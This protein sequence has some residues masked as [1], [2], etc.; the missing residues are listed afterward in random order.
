VKILHTADWHLNSVLGRQQRNVDLKPALAQIASYL[1][2]Y[3]VDVM[4][5]AGDIFRERSRAE[6]IDVGIDLI[7]QNFLPFLKRGGTIIAI[8]GNHDSDVFFN[9]L[10][11]ALDLSSPARKGEGDI[12]PSG[13]FYAV[14]YPRLLR[15]ADREGNIVQFVL[16]P[17]PTPRYL[18][19]EELDFHSLDER[20]RRIK[21]AFTKTLQTLQRRLITAQPSVLV[22]HV[23]MRGIQTDTQYT[24]TESNEAILD[25]SDLHPS[26]AYVALGHVHKPQPVL[27]GAEHMRY[28]G[29]IERMDYGERDDKKSVIIFEVRG[30]RL[31]GI[32][33]ALFLESTPFYRIEITDPDQ[34]IPLLAERYPDHR[35]A[36]VQYILHWD[37]TNPTLQSRET[38]CQQI[39]RIFPR[40]YERSFHDPSTGN[41][42]AMGGLDF[43]H[44]RDVSGTVREYISANAKP[45]EREDLLQL[46]EQLL[47]EEG[48][49]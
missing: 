17:Y 45:Q 48:L 46:A 7:K 5:V 16:M 3:S 35:R 33:Q 31:V 29:S 39:E 42:I 47:Q 32:P 8:S 27:A 44:V 14:P 34:E 24:V 6:Q 15:L 10:R 25:Y 21:E 4:L 22:S 49:V 13:R 19:G 37:A 2:Q 11:N 28:A 38:Y 23:M 30:S 43:R 36:L 9:M 40:W 26:W 12:D 1:E 18:V 41:T 20:N